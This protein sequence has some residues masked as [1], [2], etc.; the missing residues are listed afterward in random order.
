VL[1]ATS[2][3]HEPGDDATLAQDLR[4]GRQEAARRLV[5]RYEGLLIGVCSRLL[6]HRQD[7]EDVVQETFVRALR[8]IGRFDPARPLRPWLIGI[9]VNRCRTWRSRS[10][11]RVVAYGLLDDHA[12]RRAAVPD[13]DDLAGALEV[14][15]ARLRSEYRAVFVLYH[16]RGLPYEEIAASLDRPVGT[17]KTWLHRARAQLAADLARGGHAPGASGGPA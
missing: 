12:D 5:E 3:P 14:A 13:P 11:R 6:G 4:S 2:A 10:R 15:L 9:A 1:Q 8:G 16:E 7:A 17:I